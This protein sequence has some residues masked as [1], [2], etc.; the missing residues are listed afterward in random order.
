MVKKIQLRFDI[1]QVIPLD[2]SALSPLQKNIWKIMLYHTDHTV[3]SMFILYHTDHTVTSMFILY[4][5]VTSMFILYHTEHTV[6]SMFI[7]YHMTWFVSSLSLYHTDHTVTSM[8]IL[9]HMTWFV[10]SLSLSLSYRSYTV[11]NNK[12]RWIFFVVAFLE[13]SVFSPEYWF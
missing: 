10:S 12:R 5:T 13:F 4:H 11:T 8:F 9:Y 1:W 3:T 2:L 6:T 7:L